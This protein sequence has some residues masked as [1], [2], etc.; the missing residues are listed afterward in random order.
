MAPSA[1]RR[2][3]YQRFRSAVVR[4]LPAPVAGVARRAAGVVRGP[5]RQEHQLANLQS[6]VIGAMAT[7]EAGVVGLSQELGRLR[8]EVEEL[9]R[10]VDRLE[11]AA[12]ADH[13][14]T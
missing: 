11:A 8:A 13:D 12:R 4:R 6:T 14:P 1:D 10:R 5:A 2:A 9:A 3:S 7:N